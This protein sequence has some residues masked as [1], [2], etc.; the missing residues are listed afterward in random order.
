MVVGAG[1]T[2]VEMA[3]QIAELSRH[4]LKRDFRFINTKHARVIL[5]DAAGQVLPPFGTKLGEKTKEALEDLGVEVQLGAMVSDVDERGLV[6]QDKDGT[7]AGSSG[8]QDLGR[9]RPG[10]P[11]GQDA[12]RAVRGLA[13]PGRPH[14]ASTPTSPCPATPRCSWSAT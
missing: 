2:G 6:V 3:G 10:Q 8:H 4:T 14:R 11:A 13:R 1:P 12:G 9:R 5:I 7:S